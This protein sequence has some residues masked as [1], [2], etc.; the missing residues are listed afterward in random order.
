MLCCSDYYLCAM[1]LTP[2]RG[3]VVCLVNSKNYPS[4]R[5]HWGEAISN[6][7][8]MDCFVANSAPRNDGICVFDVR[9]SPI[10][11]EAIYKLLCDKLP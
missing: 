10:V 3:Q 2:I 9:H 7:V 4:L 6:Y 5:A 11:A 8:E 1:I